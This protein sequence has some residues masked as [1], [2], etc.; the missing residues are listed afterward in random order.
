VSIA[1]AE[2]AVVADTLESLR[3]DVEQK[4]TDELVCRQSHGFLL[5]VVTVVLPLKTDLPVLDTDQAVVGNGHPVSVAPNVVENLVGSGKGFFGIDYPFGLPGRSEIIGKG[6]WIF[7]MLERGKELE[8]AG[9]KSSLQK[10]KEQTA[11]QATEYSNR[12]EEAGAARDPVI[13]IRRKSATSDDTMQMRMMES[14]LTVP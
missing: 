8:F 1:I 7:K 13:A 5:V 6:H 11:E 10:L 4:A 14:A 3:Q 2:E 9:F 12:Q